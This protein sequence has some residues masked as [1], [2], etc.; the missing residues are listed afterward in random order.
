MLRLTSASARTAECEAMIGA[1]DSATA[2]IIEAFDGCETSTMM[3]TLFS[4]AMTCL[5]SG[6]K[7]FH[8]QPSVSPVFESESWLWPLCASER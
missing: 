6:D 3:P 5:P 1:F 7:P 2:C 4:S 8:F